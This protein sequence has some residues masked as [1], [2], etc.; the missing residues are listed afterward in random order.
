MAEKPNILAATEYHAHYHSR[1]S[2]FPL[3]L[4]HGVEEV[5]PGQQL[6]QPEFRI[7]LD[8]QN[9]QPTPE[10]CAGKNLKG[11]CTLARPR[12]PPARTSRS[13]TDARLQAIAIK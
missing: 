7:S 8:Q 13:T 12:A 1:C 11:S 2:F 10:S 6:C 3:E 5:S 4:N 9:P